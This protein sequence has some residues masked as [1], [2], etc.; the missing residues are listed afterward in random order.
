M[1]CP[2]ERILKIV[3]KYDI[4]INFGLAPNPFGFTFESTDNYKLNKLLSD[5]LF[6]IDCSHVK[7]TKLRKAL[8]DQ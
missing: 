2:V 7:S 3:S 4:A 8:Y 5:L 1:T 6:E